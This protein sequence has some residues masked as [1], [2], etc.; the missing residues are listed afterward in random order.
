MEAR[1]GIVPVYPPLFSEEQ[2][3]RAVVVNVDFV[4]PHFQAAVEHFL[5]LGFDLAAKAFIFD[6]VDLRL[7]LVLLWLLGVAQVAVGET[8]AVYQFVVRDRLT[9]DSRLRTPSSARKF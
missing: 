1:S 7:Y 3:V 2:A 6:L 5:R 9:C 4:V 8:F